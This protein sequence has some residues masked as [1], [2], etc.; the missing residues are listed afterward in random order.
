MPFG[1]FQTG[2]DLL[3]F[4][5]RAYS[6]QPQFSF[7]S[8]LSLS[9]TTCTVTSFLAPYPSLLKGLFIWPDAFGGLR[10]GETKGEQYP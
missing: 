4:S 10:S 2:R 6:R 1:R 8:A 3:A 5:G 7:F 9:D